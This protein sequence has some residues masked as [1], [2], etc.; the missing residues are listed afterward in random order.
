MEKTMS[1][2]K[3]TRKTRELTEDELSKWSDVEIL[4]STR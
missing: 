2:N 1:K 3:D 4:P